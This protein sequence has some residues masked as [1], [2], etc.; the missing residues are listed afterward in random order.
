[1]RTLFRVQILTLFAAVFML[2]ANIAAAEQ[3]TV[4]MNDGIGKYLADDKGMTLYIFKKDTPNKSV[5]GTAN[6]CIEKWPAF[7]AE[8]IAPDLGIDTAQVA[9]ITREDGKK[10][11]TYKGMPLY[12]FIKDKNA[13][14]TFGQGVNN[15]WFVIA[16]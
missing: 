13:G 14:E 9:E 2:F 6:G 1:M 3:L 11:T 10:Q 7:F 5:C 12:Y 16:P 8:K 4:K 15:V